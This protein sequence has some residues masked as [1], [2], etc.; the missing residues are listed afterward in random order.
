MTTADELLGPD[1]ALEG[2]D[3]TLPSGRTVRVRGLSRKDILAAREPDEGIVAFESV[4][5]ARGLVAPQLTVEQADAWQSRPGRAG[6]VRAAV[7]RI[8]ELS[9]LGEGA[10]K[11]ALPG[12]GERP[13]D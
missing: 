11:S 9:G 4:V 7:D 5:I 13:V 10:G 6:D 1:D 2:E 3:L 12:D 8:Y